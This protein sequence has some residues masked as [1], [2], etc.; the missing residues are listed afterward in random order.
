MVL[1]EV[2]APVGSIRPCG[3][4]LRL[5]I[6]MQCCY[7]AVMRTTVDLPPDLHRAA[8][9]LARDRHQSLSRTIADLL[10]RGLH[11]PGGP[12]VG[13]SELRY[14]NGFPTLTGGTGQTITS[15]DVRSLDDE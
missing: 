1:G 14:R 4:L 8:V 10:R 6:T 7:D 3:D 2:A 11:A 12:D 5:S 15:E 13:P 9:A